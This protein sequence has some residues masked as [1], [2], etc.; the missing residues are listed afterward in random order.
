MLVPNFLVIG[1]AKAGTTA[2]YDYLRQHPQ[3]FMTPVKETNYFASEERPRDYGGPGDAK[4]NEHSITARD[5]YCDQFRDLTTETA[6]GE[7]S[8][9]YLYG[10][11]VPER[12]RRQVPDAR[13]VAVL[14]HPP[15]CAYS[16][17]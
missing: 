5:A 9:L 7:A 14:R 11:T 15:D 10:P 4:W 13:L 16:A 2:L 12:L 1:A 3:V 17:F 6:V 8:P